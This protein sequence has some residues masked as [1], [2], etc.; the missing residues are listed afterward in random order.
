M[1]PESEVRPG[2]VSVMMPV[3]NVETYVGPAIESLL[4]QTYSDWELVVVDDGSTDRTSAA[5]SV[6]KD[7]RV[8]NHRQDNLGEAAARNHALQRMRGEWI[9]FLDGDD[10]FLPEHL[11]LA[12]RRLRSSPAVDA[13]YTDGFTIDEDGRRGGRLSA[14]RRGPFEGDLL[15]PLVRAS[16]VIGPPICAVLRRELVLERQLTFDTRIVIGPDWD[17]LTAFAEAAIFGYIAEATCSYRLHPKSISAQT[18]T[19][20]RDTSLAQ[21]RLNAIQRPGFRRCSLETRSYAFYD[22]L[23]NLL[24]NETRRQLDVT[25]M[26]QFIE[27]PRTEQARLLRLMAGQS[28]RAGQPGSQTLA[29]LG[30]AVELAPHDRRS[31]L[32]LRLYQIHPRLGQW[33]LRLRAGAG[34]SAPSA[35]A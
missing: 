22:L 23:V 27:L 32:L 31:R 14:R 13:V 17:F 20:L 1:R 2:L 3:H 8:H 18:G 29:W 5:L 33:I 9:A 21:C 34:R 6:F 16:D 30:R 12:I 24:A 11:E 35:R 10:L 15:D 19:P 4:G 25:G 26:P 28:L 7:P